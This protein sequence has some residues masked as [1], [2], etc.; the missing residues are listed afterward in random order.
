MS[1]EIRGVLQPVGP[2]PRRLDAAGVVR[3]DPQARKER[4]RFGRFVRRR[5]MLERLLVEPLLTVPC[6][7]SQVEFPNDLGFPAGQLGSQDVAEQV[8]IAVPRVVAVEWDQE[9]VRLLPGSQTGR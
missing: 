5:E 1:I 4:D 9:Q 3:A 7:R 8:V 6:G 2:P